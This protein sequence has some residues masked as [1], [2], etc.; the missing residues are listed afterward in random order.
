M[1]NLRSSRKNHEAGKID[2]DAENPPVLW[3]DDDVSLFRSDKR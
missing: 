2:T 3:S 1:L